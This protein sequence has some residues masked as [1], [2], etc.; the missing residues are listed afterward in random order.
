MQNGQTNGRQGKGAAKLQTNDSILSMGGVEGG[1]ATEGPVILSDL[2]I[3][4][5]LSQYLH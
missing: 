1:V 3:P 5:A 2:L 4:S